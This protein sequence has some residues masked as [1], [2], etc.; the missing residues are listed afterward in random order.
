VTPSRDRWAEWLAERR[1]GGDPELRQ[2]SLSKLAAVRDT[3]LERAALAEGERLLDVG[4]GEGLIAFGA[5]DRGARIVTF[6]DISADLLDFCRE[7]AADLGV[8]ERCEFVQAPADDVAPVGDGSINVV[9]T[10]SVLI[11]V[12]DKQRA[13]GE[14]ARVLQPGGRISIFEPINRFA[15]EPASTRFA[16]YDLGGLDDIATKLRGVFDATQHPDTDPMVDFDERDLIR[17]AD[18]AGF[19]PINL[20]LEAVVEPLP[21]RDWDGFLDAAGN[22]N[23]P[24]IRE[25][26]QLALTFAERERLTAHLRP[27][28][29]RGDGVWRMATAFLSATKPA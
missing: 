29:E 26:M 10:R 19:F 3:V 17:L 11:Y 12:R 7:A 8:L 24:T 13:F 25:A 5:L 23:I 4:C 9:T 18:A 28:V 6:A 16:G 15:H 2:R 1:F 20:A 21:A 27:L 14:F 22:P